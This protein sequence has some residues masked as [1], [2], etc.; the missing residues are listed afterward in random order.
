MTS[1]KQELHLFSGNA[2]IPHKSLTKSH[3]FTTISHVQGTSP[4]WLVN[5]LIDNALY[6]TCLL[7]EGQST[8]SSVKSGVVFISLINDSKTYEA[9]LKKLG[10]DLKSIPQFQFIDLFTDLFTKVQPQEPQSIAKLF[11][12]EVFPHISKTKKPIIFIEGLELLL[13]STQ[14]TSIQLLGYLSQLTSLSKSLF[15]ITPSDSELH[16]I[17]TIN[18]QSSRQ[19]QY[20]DFLIRVLHRTNL[21]IALRPLSTGKA[22]DVTGTLTISRGSV[23]FEGLDGLEILE[24]EYL[25]LVSRDNSVKLFFR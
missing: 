8:R 15:L 10:V 3:L 20:H 13:L 18:T 17:T 5:Y 25:Y 6:D 9:G 24:R 11:D 16:D 4:T 2:I 22:K 14:I 1:Q 19:H 12:S 21:N 7:N 23:P